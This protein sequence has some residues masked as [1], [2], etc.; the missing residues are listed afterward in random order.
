MSDERGSMKWRGKK[1]R[2]MRTE[3][4]AGEQGAEA[5]G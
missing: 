1:F 5:E 4:R 2:G 3:G